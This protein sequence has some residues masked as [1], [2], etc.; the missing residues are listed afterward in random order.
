MQFRVIDRY[1]K[2]YALSPGV[3]PKTTFGDTSHSSIGST[4]DTQT[5]GHCG[6]FAGMGYSG[7]GTGS[8]WS[9][10]SVL[11]NSV[12]MIFYRW[13]SKFE[14]SHSRILWFDT[15]G[16]HR[17]NALSFHICNS[18]LLYFFAHE[19]TKRLMMKIFYATHMRNLKQS[20]PLDSYAWSRSSHD[21]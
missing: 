10:D 5:T 6:D 11:A 1:R 7:V 15:N 17:R 12:F 16:Q 14:L 13:S 8:A 19:K 4:G 21:S 18:R 3:R 9:A 2:A 20:L